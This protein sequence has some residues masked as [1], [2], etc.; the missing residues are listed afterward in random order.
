MPPSLIVSSCRR[1]GFTAHAI[2]DRPLDPLL[3]ATGRWPRLSTIA[4]LTKRYIGRA[5]PLVMNRG[6]FVVLTN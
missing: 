6:H 4:N 2:H 1:A 5:T 3:I